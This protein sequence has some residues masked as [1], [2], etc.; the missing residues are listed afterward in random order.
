VALIGNLVVAAVVTLVLRGSRTP[1]GVDHTR[2]DDYHATTVPET[3]TPE[4]VSPV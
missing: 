1:D 2:S 4:A 3:T